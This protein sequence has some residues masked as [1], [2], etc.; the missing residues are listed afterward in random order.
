MSLYID[1]LA[2]KIIAKLAEQGAVGPTVE[3]TMRRDLDAGADIWTVRTAPAYDHPD[4]SGESI[5]DAMR[6]MAREVGAL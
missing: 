3:V 6:T 2:S 5:Q 1:G 4:V